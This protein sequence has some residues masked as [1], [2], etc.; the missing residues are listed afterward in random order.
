MESNCLVHEKLGC[1]VKGQIASAF[2]LCF[3]VFLSLSHVV[4]WVRNGS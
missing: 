1:S 2:L 4:S 3:L